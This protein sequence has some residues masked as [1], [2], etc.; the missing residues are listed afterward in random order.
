MEELEIALRLTLQGVKKHPIVFGHPY[1]LT[2]IWFVYQ[3]IVGKVSLVKYGAKILV[4]WC[5]AFAVLAPIASVML[6]SFVGGGS[7]SI[8]F[9]IF[10]IVVFLGAAILHFGLFPFYIWITIRQN[11]GKTEGII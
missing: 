8:I 11:S 2:A 7:G 6:W 3:L 4:R 9:N 1:I 10:A 5:I